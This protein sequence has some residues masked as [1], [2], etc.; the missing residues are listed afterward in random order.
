MGN[1]QL[2][3]PKIGLNPLKIKKR[4]L[5]M[6]QF[7]G[8]DFF[9]KTGKRSEVSRSNERLIPSFFIMIIQSKP[10]SDRRYS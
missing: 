10:C 7:M 1:L 6:M 8:E 4:S 3:G 9:L 2:A 5:P